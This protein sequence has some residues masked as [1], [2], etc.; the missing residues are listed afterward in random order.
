MRGQCST[1]YWGC[2]YLLS[3]IA[4]VF[5]S[6]SRKTSSLV[7]FFLL[8]VNTQEP[9]KERLKTFSRSSNSVCKNCLTSDGMIQL[10][11]DGLH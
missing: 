7:S 8:Q 10:S 3:R 9:W 2:S 11:I 6:V 5:Y 1:C 4:A